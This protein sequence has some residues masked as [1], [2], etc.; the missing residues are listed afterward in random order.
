M[1]SFYNAECFSV[2]QRFCYNFSHHCK[3]TGSS[4]AVPVGLLFFLTVLVMPET[5]GAVQVH[6]TPEGLYVHQMAHVFFAAAL[7]F[8]LL[9]LH[10]RPIGHGTAL[11]Y[12]KYSLLF[13][14]L[15]NIDTFTVHWLTTLISDSAIVN[16]GKLW[17]HQLTRPLTVKSLLYYFGRLDHLLC[18]PAMW[19]LVQSLRNFCIEAEKQQ[20]MAEEI[21]P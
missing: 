11:R 15:W 5:A 9:L 13:F 1:I 2:L 21:M 20:T 12:L 7:I 19:F 10:F 3:L 18:L 4:F 6:G 16:E 17:Q 8:L 14:L